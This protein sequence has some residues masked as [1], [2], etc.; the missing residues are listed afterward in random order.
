MKTNKLTAASLEL[1]RYLINTTDFC[2]DE[3]YD[4]GCILESEVKAGLNKY[5]RGN[6]SDLKKKNLI[7]MDYEED[8]LHPFR[9]CYW[10]TLT[11]EGQRVAREH[12]I[13]A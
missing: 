8:R 3:G 1:F 11:E 9:N 10:V 12:G 2:Y 7:W 6:L 13:I 4:V 5:K